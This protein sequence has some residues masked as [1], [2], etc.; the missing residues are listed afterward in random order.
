[1][2]QAP[3]KRAK[4]F[5][6][7]KALTKRISRETEKAGGCVTPVTGGLGKMSD[8]VGIREAARRLGVSAPT[9]SR[10]IQKHPELNQ[11]N[12]SPK[13]DFEELKAHRA[14]NVNPAMSGNHAGRLMGEVPEAADGVAGGGGGGKKSPSL[15][16]AKTRREVS[17]ADKAELDLQERLKKLTDTAG[18][19]DGAF[20]AGQILRELLK[21]R[22]RRLGDKFAS[23]GDP[24]GITAAL[25]AEDRDLLARLVEAIHERIRTETDAA[26]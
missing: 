8:I 14:S 17:Q 26:A 12:G 10:Y 11:G 3:V 15:L 19:E 24:R 22:N 23:M 21:A 1:M 16:D 2:Q 25:E 5:N 4:S 6:K 7:N 20:E 13:V 9:I 18:V